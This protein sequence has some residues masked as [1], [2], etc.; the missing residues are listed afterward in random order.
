[1]GCG[2]HV[3][4]R[5]LHL[6]VFGAHVHAAHQVGLVLLVGQPPCRGAGRAALA[7]G[8]HA[9]ATC[10]GCGESVGMDAHKQVGLHA[11]RLLHTGA[12]GHKV[13]AI[14]R[15]K[16]PHRVAAHGGGVDAIAQQ[17]G[18]AQHHIFFARA[19]WADGAWVFATV[20]GVERN[21]D[22]A[23][24]LCGGGAVVGAWCWRLGLHAGRSGWRRCSDDR[25][26]GFAGQRGTALCNQ[27]AQ[28]VRCASGCRRCAGRARCTCESCCTGRRG[29]WCRCRR[30]HQ[31]LG[32]QSLQRVDRRG[33]IQVKHQPIAVGRHGR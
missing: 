14:A 8:K 11:P 2:A 10:A 4:Q 23:V 13:V 1:M 17:V 30:V 7:Q 25:R 32:D 26:R 33:G 27:V 21:D 6:L 5:A 3:Q 28:R 16:G 18:H 22:D 29:G 15:E 12:Q 24:G 20:S 19:R 31:P 9:C